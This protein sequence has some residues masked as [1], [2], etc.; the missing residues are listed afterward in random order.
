MFAAVNR[1]S[2]EIDK[3]LRGWADNKV[4][5]Q[6]VHSRTNDYFSLLLLFLYIYKPKLALYIQRKSA[7][8]TIYI[9]IIIFISSNSNN[10]NNIIKNTTTTTNNNYYNKIIIII[11]I[12]IPFRLGRISVYNTISL[13]CIYMH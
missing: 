13:S 7:A 2:K 4:T 8:I 12:I 6:H 11:I 5:D 9:I 3:H 10:N 1:F